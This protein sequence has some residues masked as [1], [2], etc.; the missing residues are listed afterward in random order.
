M[1]MSQ[2][3]LNDMGAAWSPSDPAVFTMAIDTTIFADPSGS[4]GLLVAKSGASGKTVEFDPPTPID[5]SGFDEIRFWVLGDRTADGSPAQPFLLEFSFVDGDDQPGEEHR[6]FVPVN[7]PGVWEQR[8]IGIL[9]ER[10]SHVT[11]LR[12]GAVTDAPFACH[13]DEP[14]AVREEMVADL[15]QA[16]RDALGAVSLPGATGVLLAV[17]AHPGDT[18]V[19]LALAT[20]FAP[21]NRVRLD[22]RT[23]GPR[24]PP[25]ASPPPH[26]RTVATTPSC[27][28]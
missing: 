11:R 8:R 26:A 5:L 20:E 4:S 2:L 10:R 12:F 25:V 16:L 15:E 9:A 24:A 18:Q 3:L 21:G 14:L 27:A 19:V 6:W 22:S 13:V 28:T 7:R 23:A 17:A 1:P